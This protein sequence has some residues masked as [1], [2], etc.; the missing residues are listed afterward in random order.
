MRYLFNLKLW[1]ILLLI[2]TFLIKEPIEGILLSNKF[3]KSH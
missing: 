2:F 3:K 1:Q